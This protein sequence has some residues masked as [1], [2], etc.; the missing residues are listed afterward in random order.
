[1]LKFVERKNIDTDKWDNTVQKSTDFSIYGLSWYLDCVCDWKGLIYDDYKWVLPLPNSRKYLLNYVYMPFG[2]QRFSIYGEE[3][4]SSE[5]AE[6]FLNQLIK[7][8]FTINLSLEESISMDRA[9]IKVVKH[10][11]Q[12]LKLNKTYVEIY[13]DFSTSHKRNIKKGEKNNLVI[14]KQS[15]TSE[16]KNLIRSFYDKKKI[17]RVHH[18]NEYF[19]LIAELT[20]RSLIDIFGVYNLNNELQNV[21]IYTCLDNNRRALNSI[22]SDEG[23]SNGAMFFGFNE[24]VKMNSN[25]NIIIDFEGSNIDSIRRRN[26]GFGG[27]DEF[28]NSIS[29]RKI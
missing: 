7:K 23:A 18:L 13:N 20:E 5:I 17:K 25:S 1:M 15:I 11:S 19:D 24:Y 8:Y 21:S 28:Y 10:K 6:L 29:Y 2:I 26:V 27:V 22:N 9:K 14:K 3:S 16:M 12:Y 4:V